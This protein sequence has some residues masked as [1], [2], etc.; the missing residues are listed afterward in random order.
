MGFTRQGYWSGFSFPS[1][2]DLPNPGIKPRSPVLQAD[3]LPT[4]LWGKPHVQDSFSQLLGFLYLWNFLVSLCICVTCVFLLSSCTHLLFL[5]IVFDEDFMCF[6][7]FFLF[8]SFNDSSYL[9]KLLS[10]SMHMY[11][12]THIY[13]LAALPTGVVLIVCSGR[14]W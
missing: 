7:F 11:V 2:G 10:W 12:M 14:G 13:L 8:W 3:D 6:F 5:V 9:M 1:P 4:E